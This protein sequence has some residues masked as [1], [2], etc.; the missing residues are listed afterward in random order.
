[1]C[2]SMVN[3]Q[4]PTA[5]I[6]RGKKRKKERKKKQVVKPLWQPVWQ[7][8]GCL[9]TRYSRLSYRLYNRFD[10]RLYCVNRV[11][12]YV[13]MLTNFNF[14]YKWIIINEFKFNLWFIVHATQNLVMCAYLFFVADPTHSCTA[15]GVIDSQHCALYSING[16]WVSSF[17]W[18]DKHSP[19]R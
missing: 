16:R 3:I 11:L 14:T 1:M 18:T 17:S 15:L 13:V 2:Q 5:E 7:P 12:G 8:V 6:R 9:F 19:S 4:S 10:N